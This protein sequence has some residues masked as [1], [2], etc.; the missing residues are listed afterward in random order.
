MSKKVDSDEPTFEHAV[1]V[2]SVVD[3]V[4]AVEYYRVV[5]GFNPDWTWGE[6][7]L[8]ASVTRGS[9]ELHLAKRGAAG[10]P[11]VST[12]YVFL[13]G[14]D[15][16]YAECRTKSAKI[17]NDLANQAYGMREFDV[18]DPDGNNLCFGEQTAC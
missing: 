12:V 3:V 7:P 18:E 14:I 4:Q 1:P 6:P 16:Y 10:P 8:M 11:G 2:L 15:K 9:V 13:S 5:L 17:L